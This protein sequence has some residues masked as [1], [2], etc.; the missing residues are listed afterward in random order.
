MNR[1][2]HSTVSKMLNRTVSS[3]DREVG[4]EHSQAQRELA[5]RAPHAPSKSQFHFVFAELRAKIRR[6]TSDR[7]AVKRLKLR[8]SDGKNSAVEAASKMSSRPDRSASAHAR[9]SQVPVRMWSDRVAEVN[10]AAR[11]QRMLGI[12][13]C[14]I[15][16]ILKH[17]ILAQLRFIA[18]ANDRQ[19]RCPGGANPQQ[20]H[21]TIE[22]RRL[23]AASLLRVVTETRP[24]SV[25]FRS[26]E[27]TPAEQ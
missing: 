24:R 11:I 26:H 4:F 17:E 14:S 7:D 1:A 21:R 9:M 12:V 5:C 18:R 23:T 6:T 19:S 13:E 25:P 3:W 27:T 2:F 15:Q 20:I 10:C 22:I 8:T 16:A